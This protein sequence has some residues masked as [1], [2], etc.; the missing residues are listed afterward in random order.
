MMRGRIVQL[1]NGY[2]FISSEGL[3][4]NLF[5]FWEDL[6]NIDFND[7]RI[8]DEVEYEPGRNDRGDCARRIHRV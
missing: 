6:E 4:K 2:G 8:G 1:K 7:L 5:F 3:Q